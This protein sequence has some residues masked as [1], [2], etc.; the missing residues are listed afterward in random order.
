MTQDDGG[1]IRASAPDARPDTGDARAGQTPKKKAGRGSPGETSPGSIFGAVAILGGWASICLGAFLGLARSDFLGT[2]NAVGPQPPLT[3][4]GFSGAV[5]LWLFVAAA[6]LA[7]LPVGMALLAPDPRQV[8]NAAAVVM[9]I[10]GLLLLPDELGRAFGL[11][12]LPGSAL[13]A[14]GG[15]LIQPDAASLDHGAGGVTADAGAT[16]RDR[17]T[18]G[19]PGAAGLEP[20]V[21]QPVPTP[22]RN[23]TPPQPSAVDRDCPWCSARV[24]S[25]ASTC[26][27]CHAT[28]DADPV[29]DTIQLPGVTEV[30]PELRAYAEE[31][32][33]GKKKRRS[34][35]NLLS[36]PSAPV[37]EVAP[38]PSE[39]YAVLPPSEAVRAEMARLDTEIAARAVLPGTEPFEFPGAMSPEPAPDGAPPAPDGKPAPDAAPPPAPR[40]RRTPPA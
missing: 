15:W 17:L 24:P 19:E 25:S 30:S 33:A 23:G 10:A 39:R 20:G 31:A 40:G 2:G 28:I 11:P 32:R 22:A 38:D 36:I 1:P 26:P 9:A 34:L 35:S 27:A 37:V 5:V 6:L 14:F 18:A 21:A 3:V 7:A 4:Y 13:V 8:T 16:A 12:L 29:V